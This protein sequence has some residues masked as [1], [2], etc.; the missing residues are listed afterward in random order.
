M[1]RLREEQKAPMS[2]LREEQK[3]PMS[4]LRE[5]QKAP[6]SRLR[7]EQTT[8]RFVGAQSGPLALRKAAGPRPRPSGSTRQ[9]TNRR[10][11]ASLDRHRAG[12]RIGGSSPRWRS[13]VCSRRS[14][15]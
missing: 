3:A 14:W 12:S 5:E 9:L 6:M 4:R 2:R 13:H 7:E 10:A 15:C 1:S 11:P 8:N